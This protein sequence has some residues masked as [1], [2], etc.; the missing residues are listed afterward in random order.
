MISRRS[1]LAGLAVALPLSAAAAGSTDVVIGYLDRANDSAYAVK[2]SYETIRA[3]SIPSPFPGAALAIADAK[4][5]GDAAGLAFKLERATLE[6]GDDAATAARALASEKHAAAIIL[7]L[8]KDETE[9]VAKALSD[10]PIALF[11]ARHRTP[12][13]RQSACATH[14]FHTIPS[15][16]MLTDALAQGLA[17]RNWTRVLVVASD[18]PEDKAEAETF[19]ASAAKF[20]LTIVAVKTFAAG[21][22]PRDRERNNPRLITGDAVYDVVYLADHVGDF[23][24]ALPY[25]TAL[26][27]PIVGAAGLVATAWHP[28]WERQGA[29]QLNHRFEKAAKHPMSEIDWAT[30]VAARAI[31][32]A[33]VRGKARTATDLIPALIAATLTLELYK[34]NAGSFRPWNRQLRQPILLATDTAVAGFTP[35]E[36]ML[37]QTNTLD[38]LGLDEPE[39]HCP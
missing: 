18:D 1:F 22:D 23:A 10:L 26:P 9:A 39:F 20:G 31:V 17:K 12:M 34:G 7:D 19:Q 38:T 27:R 4:L 8:P 36:G 6:D 35:V 24:R 11:N 3:A 14:L 28:F 25:N 5:I 33:S 21:N 30:W 15:S 16:D 13:L 2:R 32:E 37:H 29:P